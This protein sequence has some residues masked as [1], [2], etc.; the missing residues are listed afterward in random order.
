[1]QRST[2]LLDDIVT[3]NSGKPSKQEITWSEQREYVLVSVIKH[4]NAH[5]KT[6]EMKMEDKK[7]MAFNDLRSHASFIDVRDVLTAN[8][9]MQKFN[10][11][12]L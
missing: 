5:M 9:M 6:K 3:Q 8:G 2:V 12:R 11:L 7:Q 1:M 10:R 4:R